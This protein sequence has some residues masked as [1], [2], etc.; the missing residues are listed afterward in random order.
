MVHL[1]AL[2]FWH[3]QCLFLKPEAPQAGIIA[4]NNITAK[5]WRRADTPHTSKC[6]ELS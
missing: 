1:P 2:H 6:A 4:H 3:W 5:H